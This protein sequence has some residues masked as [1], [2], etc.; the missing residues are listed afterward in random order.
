MSTSTDDAPARR[1]AVYCGSS[2]GHDEVHAAVATDLGRTIARRGHG[3]VFGGG[4]V[5]LMGIVADA[6]LAE[7]GEVVGVMT[8]ALVRA[9]V[10]HRGLDHL[11]IVD[12]MHERKARMTELVRGVVVLPGGF[13]TLDEAFEVLTWNQL[14]IVA[15]PVVFVDVDGYYRPLLD[16]VDA[17]VERGFVRSAHRDLVLRASTAAEAVEAVESEAPPV[18]PKWRGV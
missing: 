9:E 17:A 10:A 14:G 16:F 11:E 12:T 2:T 18:T 5:G 7:G 8:A 6:A 4:H 13:G 3:L 1:I 15:V